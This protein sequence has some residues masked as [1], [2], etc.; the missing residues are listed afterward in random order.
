MSVPNSNSNQLINPLVIGRESLLK[1]LLCIFYL[2]HSVVSIHC[3]LKMKIRI[4][5]QKKIERSFLKIKKMSKSFL[6]D[7]WLISRI[8]FWKNL[9]KN[10][11]QSS[12]LILISFVITIEIRISFLSLREEENGNQIFMIVT[13]LFSLVGS[14]LL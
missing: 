9:S 3:R 13:S 11:G 7:L 12:A 2:F 4:L 1:V 14:V 5:S 8:N 10:E 6:I